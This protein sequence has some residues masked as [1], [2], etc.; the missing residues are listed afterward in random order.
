MESRRPPDFDEEGDLDLIQ[1]PGLVAR[2]TRELTLS[3]KIL[4]AAVVVL[5]LLLVSHEAAMSL[6][7]PWLDPRRLVV[8]L[9]TFRHR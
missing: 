7:L 2:H 4:I 9:F 3:T 6:H 1:A 5:M 8:K